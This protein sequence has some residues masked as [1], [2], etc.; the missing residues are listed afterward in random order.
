[1]PA[2]AARIRTKRISEKPS[3]ADGTRVL[4]DLLPRSVT[5]EQGVL[6]RWLKQLAPSDELQEWFREN[7]QSWP[8]FCKRYFKELR[9]PEK[10]DALNELYQLAS[11][12]KPLTLLHASKDE[13]HNN[14]VVL[15]ELLG[16]KRKP[17]TGSGPLRSAQERQVKRMPNTR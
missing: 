16:G 17:P 6:D 4:V 5:K 8:V 11:G 7:P 12:R 9:E 15:R 14:A 13:Q 2:F 3:R 1:M 10:A